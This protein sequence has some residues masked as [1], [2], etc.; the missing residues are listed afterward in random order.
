MNEVI[1]QEGLPIALGSLAMA[2]F[3]HPLPQ[4]GDRENA[5]KTTAKKDPSL[6]M[7]ETGHITNTV[8]CENGCGSQLGSS[9]AEYNTNVNGPLKD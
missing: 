8:S 5:G 2:S 4:S 9:L 1:N 6:L 7:M 3:Q